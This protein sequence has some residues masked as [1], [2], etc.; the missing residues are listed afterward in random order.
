MLAAMGAEV[1]VELLPG[2]GRRVTIKGQPELRP[3]SFVVPGD[4]SSA[5]FPTVAAACAAGSRVRLEGVCLNPLRTGLY[6]TLREMQADI[7]IENERTAGGEPVGDLVVRGGDLLGV[8]VPADRAPA[9]I[10]EYPVL[11]V[12]ASVARGTSIMRGLAEL[13]VKES[14]RLATMAEGLAACGVAVEVAGD[15]LIVHGGRRPAG[16]VTI[17]AR[18]DH[19]IAMSFL[20]LGGLAAGPVQVEGAEAIE[21]S[22]PGFRDLMNGLGAAI[23]AVGPAA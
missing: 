4:P 2:G 18:L 1:A 22:F 11:A 3:Q 8:E 10:D 20:V 15:D 7:A 16:D 5:G 9:M 6:T 19:R 13:R 14:D 23:A 12:A 17:D 21:T